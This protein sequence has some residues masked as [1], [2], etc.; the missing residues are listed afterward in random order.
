MRIKK[1]TD[2]GDEGRFLGWSSGGWGT[3]MGRQTGTGCR[4]KAWNA[5]SQRR[6]L[7]RSHIR[8]REASRNIQRLNDRERERKR[9]RE[10]EMVDKG[11][12]G[13]ERW[14]KGAVT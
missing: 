1:S 8:D 10:R 5:E 4:D 3:G 6:S 9:E 7:R 2:E 11:E 12:E 14:E 13:I